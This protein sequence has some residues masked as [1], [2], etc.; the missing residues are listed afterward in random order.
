MQP[1]IP[2]GKCSEMVISSQREISENYGKPTRLSSFPE[3]PENAV[4]FVIGN[5][6]KN[7]NLNFASYGMRPE[8]I[9]FTLL[10]THNSLL[11]AR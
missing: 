9:A 1:K 4:P 2:R 7:L 5:F 3:M 6:G 8:L 11:L 10:V